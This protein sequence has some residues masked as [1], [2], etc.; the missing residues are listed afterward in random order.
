MPQGYQNVY[1]ATDAATAPAG[2]I[3]ART[4][5][6]AALAGYMET[7][8]LAASTNV[9]A[10]IVGMTSH[11]GFANINPTGH[12]IGVI[13]II[14]NQTAFLC[15]AA[16]AVEGRVQGTSGSYTSIASFIAAAETVTE[17]AAA[18][19][20][21]TTDYLS[22]TYADQAWAGSLFAFLCQDANKQSQLEGL[23]NV[24]GALQQRG[25]GVQGATCWVNCDTTSGTPVNNG[26]FNVTS[27]TDNGVGNTNVNMTTALAAGGKSVTCAC[28]LGVAIPFSGTAS[29]TTFQIITYAIAT[30]LLT[31]MLFCATV[32]GGT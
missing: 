3:T 22:T 13:G 31:D 16:Y 8:N 17:G 18:T 14:D 2:S 11:R 24:K 19:A 1:A 32:H 9:S 21:V 26:S 23:L 6:K 15:S 30:L 20:T 10:G 27:F 5:P 7:A 25:R 4:F 28:G 12:I 29:T